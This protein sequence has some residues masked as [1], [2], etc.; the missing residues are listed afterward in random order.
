MAIADIV[1]GWQAPKSS[2]LA[3][4]EHGNAS[5]ASAS[6]LNISFDASPEYGMIAEASGAWAARI[7]KVSEVEKSV[8]HALKQVQSGRSA[9]LNVILQAI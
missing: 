7:E 9:V 5:T 1:K 2:A 6:D 3:V 4:R 8:L